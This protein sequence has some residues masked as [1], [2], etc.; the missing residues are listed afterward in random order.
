MAVH[1]LDRRNVGI[2]PSDFQL[3][4][5]NFVHRTV[6]KLTGGKIGWTAAEKFQ[7]TTPTWRFADHRVTVGVVRLIRAEASR[8]RLA[9]APST[10][11][12]TPAD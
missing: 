7:P 1:L 6:L 11:S 4:T 9:S 10:A 2:V 8:E 12:A 3:K 5:M